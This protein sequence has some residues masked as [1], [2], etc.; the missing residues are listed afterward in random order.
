[1]YD[2]YVSLGNNCEIAFQM[3]RVR[4][5]HKGGF[6]NWNITNLDVLIAILQNDFAGL[7]QEHNIVHFQSDLFRDLQYR[8]CFHADFSTPDLNADGKFQEKLENLRSKTYHFIH[9]FRT[10]KDS[11]R[12][13]FFYKTHETENLLDRIVTVRD[14]LTSYVPYGQF[15][16][17]VAQPV[18]QLLKGQ[19]RQN[20]YFRPL[21]RLAPGNDATDGH[22]RSWDIIFREFPHR[23]GITAAFW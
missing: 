4:G 2:N 20:I 7:L 11:G 9:S 21:A 3:R 14:I 23:E 13:V 10:L 1:M 6:F 19:D 16:L 12:T 22:V 18:E 5:V 15:D 17:V 8:H